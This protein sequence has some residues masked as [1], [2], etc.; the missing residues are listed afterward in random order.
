MFL[1]PNHFPLCCNGSG[2]ESIHAKSIVAWQQLSLRSKK[3]PCRHVQQA[4]PSA[5]CDPFKCMGAPLNHYAHGCGALKWV[6]REAEGEKVMQCLLRHC[7][8]SPNIERFT[9]SNTSVNLP[10]ALLN[11]CSISETLCD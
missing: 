5:E 6:S 7:I 8:T 11:S 4:V 2:G 3:N 10:L 9:Q 1:T